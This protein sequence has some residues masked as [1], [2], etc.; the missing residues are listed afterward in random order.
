MKL[1]DLVGGADRVIAGMLPVAIVAIAANAV[2]PNAFRMGLGQVGVITGVI[3]VALGAPLWLWA[4]GQIVVYTPRGRLI[5]T[6]PYAVMLHRIY[7][8]VALLVTPGVGFVL[9]TW[10]MFLIGCA[11]Y[12]SSRVFSP[13]EE[14]YLAATFPNEYPAY[15][16][17]VLSPWL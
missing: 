9:D 14:R 16:E 1:G 5:T 6:G 2:W 15:R 10:G 7:T 3:L 8:C 17:R 12:I 11:L 13:R 4:V